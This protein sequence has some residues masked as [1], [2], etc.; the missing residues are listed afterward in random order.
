MAVVELKREGDVFILA[1][2]KEDHRFNPSLL[3]AMNQALDTVERTPGPAAM[4]TIG[5]EEKF[6]SK[7]KED[8]SSITLST[9][10][11]KKYRS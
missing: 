7:G 6:Y 10:I 3:K 8:E 4:V 9:L 5:G 11:M 2:P 1:I